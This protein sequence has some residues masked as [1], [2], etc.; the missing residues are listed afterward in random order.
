MISLHIVLVNFFSVD[1]YSDVGGQM[2]YG[3]IPTYTATRIDPDDPEPSG[4]FPLADC[5][6]FRPTCEDVT[7]ASSTLAAVDEITG[8]SFDFF[9]RQFDGTGAVVVDT[10]TTR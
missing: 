8:D 10:S 9:H 7:G 3:N 5:I 1:S 4:E 6:D 2:G